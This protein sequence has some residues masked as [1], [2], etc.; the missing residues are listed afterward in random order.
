MHKDALN[1][2]RNVIHQLLGPGGCPWDKEQTPQSLC[3]CVLEEVFELIEAIRDDNTEDA[4]EEMGDVLFLLLF[5]IELHERAGNFTLDDALNSSAAKM[6]RRHPHV[7]ADTKIKN[8]EELLKNWEK[9]KRSEKYTENGNKTGIFDSLP[10]SLPPLL[11]AYRIHSKAARSGFTWETDQDLMSQLHSEWQEWEHA[12]ASEDTTA[13]EKEYGDYL[14]TLVELGRRKGFKAN[15]ALDFANKKFLRR[16]K[17]MEQQAHA[18]GMDIAELSLEQLNSLWDH[19][20]A[21]EH[22]S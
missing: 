17:I 21:N 10:K 6:I 13:Q 18:Q 22:T 16:F 14:F 20:K 11:K 7:F 5:I 15:T 2:L 12:L 3:D 19:A 1:N 8:Q 4:I 9:I